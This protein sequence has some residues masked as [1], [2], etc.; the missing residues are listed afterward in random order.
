MKVAILTTFAAVCIQAGSR[1]HGLVVSI[2]S[3]LAS[4]A[5]IACAIAQWVIYFREWVHFEIESHEE[6]TKTK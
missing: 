3:F 6:R 4:G 1:E 2:F 5:M